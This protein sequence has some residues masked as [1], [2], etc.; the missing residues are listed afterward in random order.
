MSYW[1]NFVELKLFYLES[2]SRKWCS[3]WEPLMNQRCL[4]NGLVLN[5]YQGLLPSKF[6]ID[7]NLFYYYSF[8]D[9]RYHFGMTAHISCN[10]MRMKVNQNFHRSWIAM[11]NFGGMGPDPQIHDDTH[12]RRNVINFWRCT[13][14]TEAYTKW[15]PFCWRKFQMY[16]LQ[17]N[18]S[19][20]CGTE[21]LIVNKLSSV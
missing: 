17:R 14:Y 8:S 1:I 19:L 11:E 3:K 10:I 2:N 21:G 4:I 7:G 12:P 20:K 9:H 18:I 15:R 13:W 6:K 5:P 16:F